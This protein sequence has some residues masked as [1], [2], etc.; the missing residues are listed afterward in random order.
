MWAVLRFTR[1]GT[2][3]RAAA[4]DERSAELLG[5][6]PP[7]LAAASWIAGSA[8]GGTVAI[9][10]AAATTLDPAGFALFVVPALAAALLGQLSSVG[11]A[12]GAGLAFGAVQS[13]LTYLSTKSWWPGW[14]AA[15]FN[16]VVPLL[17]VIVA[18]FVLG[19]NLPTR[20]SAGTPRLPPVFVPRWRPAV[21][22]FAVFAAV[23]ALVVSGPTYRFGIITSMIMAIVSLSLVLLTGFAGQVSL[24]QAAFAGTGGFIMSRLA[25][26]AHVPF[27]LSLLLGAAAASVVGVVIAVPALRVR[28]SQLAIVTLAAAVAVE[29]FVFGNPGITPPLGN[30]VPDAELFGLDLAVRRGDALV[31]VEFGLLVLAVLVVVVALVVNLDAWR[32]RSSA[33]R[34]AIQRAR[35]GRAGIDVTAIKLMVFG[36]SCVPRR[37]RWRPARLQPRSDLGRVVH[38]AG[39]RIVP[40]LRLPGRHHQFDGCVD[41][42][43]PGT[44]GIGYVV[45]NDV[46]GEQLAR[47]Y[48]LV[49]GLLLLATSILNPIGMSGQITTMRTRL[50]V[51]HPRVAPRPVVGEPACL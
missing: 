40:R 36:V 44:L 42:W 6:S 11:I 19:K 5:Y 13:Q 24:A 48:L 33:A 49:S 8:I 38:R 7:R 9:L 21:V 18:L 4:E 2:A 51:R 10:A 37:A 34:G 14:A 23:A 25:T 15:G 32:R 39:R 47:Y 30:T 22:V 31:R 28:G 43:G 3:L 45:L 1:R 26:A 12:V 46:V 35:R 20:A 50:S 29:R 27:P 41:R 16:D 17:V